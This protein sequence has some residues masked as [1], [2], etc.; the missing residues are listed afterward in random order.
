M[1]SVSLS[2]A[3]EDHIRTVATDM[4]NLL[5]NAAFERSRIQDIKF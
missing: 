4:H 1:A 2:N 3:S 5:V